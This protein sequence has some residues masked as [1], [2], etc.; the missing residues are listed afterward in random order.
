MHKLPIRSSVKLVTLRGFSLMTQTPVRTLRDMITRRVI[1]YVK[2][3]QYIRIPVEEALE[4]LNKYK[5][6]AVNIGGRKGD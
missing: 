5:T 2:I 4:A 1:P 6:P 3:R